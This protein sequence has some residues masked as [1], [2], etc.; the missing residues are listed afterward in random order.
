MKPLGPIPEGYAARD[1]VLAIDGAK[2]TD[3]IAQSGGQ[4]PLFV[5]SSNRLRARVSQL[6]AAMP[7]RLAIHYAMKANPFRPL[8]RLMNTLVDGFDIA[9]G[10][11]LGMALAA[12]VDPA[13]ISFAGPGK[14]DMEL[15]AA[16]LQLSLI[17]I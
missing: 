5:Y 11:E 15:Q 1:G 4:T 9:S 7:E 2:I 12:G 16:I 6:R 14:R 8:L 3:I 13:R 10:G 17:H